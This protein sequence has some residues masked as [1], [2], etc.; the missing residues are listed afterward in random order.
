MDPRLAAAVLRQP[1][2]R[3][4]GAATLVMARAVQDPAYAELLLDGRHPVTGHTLPGSLTERFAAEVLAMHRRTTGPVDVRGALQLP[5]PPAFGTPPWAVANQL[6][7][8]TGRPWRARAI[9][10]S[11][12]TAYLARIRRAA[13]SVPVPVYVGN[14]WL[15]RHVVLVLDAELTTYEPASGRRVH[16]D[17]GDFVAGRLSLAGWSRP[18]FAVLPEV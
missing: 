16:V 2:Q 12:R 9:P 15:P 18:W 17:G 10:P 11:A 14:R 7:G 6:S 13:A 3:S 8:S 4:C 1:D 5:W